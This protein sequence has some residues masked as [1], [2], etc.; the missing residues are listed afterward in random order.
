MGKTKKLYN[1]LP[2]E[3]IDVASAIIKASVT[4]DL[5][6]IAELDILH[7]LPANMNISIP[8]YDLCEIEEIANH[9]LAYCESQRQ[10]VEDIERDR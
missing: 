6:G 8:K 4:T 7:G 5:S 10:G 1:L 2:D 3:P 9:L